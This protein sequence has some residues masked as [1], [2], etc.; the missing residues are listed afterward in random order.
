[1]SALA[2][3]R[4]HGLRL[5]IAGE[6]LVVAPRSALT[7]DLRALIRSQK[8]R[9]LSELAGTS[10]A[11]RAARETKVAAELR[12]HPEMRVAFDVANVP[13]QTGAGEPVSVVLAVRHGEEILSGEIH[14][15]RDR[16]DARAFVVVVES[17]SGKPS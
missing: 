11:E 16:W 4:D 13:L 12:T 2:R 7:D 5:Q 15:P 10:D 1:M 3:L 6:Q 9:I 14:I 8:Q 17:G